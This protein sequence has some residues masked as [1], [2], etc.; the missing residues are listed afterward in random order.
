MARRLGVMYIIFNRRIWFPG[1]GWRVYCKQKPRGCVSPSDGGLRHPHTDHVHFS[2]TWD[3]ARKHTTFWSPSR[4]MVAGIAGHPVSA[5]SW[6]VGGNGG[7]L[8]DGTTYYGSMAHV[9][10]KRPIVD[11]TSTP[12]GNGYWLLRSDGRVLA[13]GDAVKRGSITSDNKRVVG[14]S[15]T[16]NGGGY[17]IVTRSGQVLSFGNAVGYGGASPSGATIAEIVATPSGQGYWLF[18]SDGRVFP[19]GDAGDFGQA[20]GSRIVGGDNH[21]SDGYWLVSEGGRV[22]SF[23]SATSFGDPAGGNLGSPVVGL[24]GTPTGEGYVVITSKGR[25]YRFGDA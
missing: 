12:S 5:S 8:T 22:R 16:A 9:W 6:S 23:G 20:K 14:M 3:G 21:G 25:I 4:S 7:V 17:W 11:M 24:A 19:F 15:A 1:S 10:L 2:F 18:A 13:Y